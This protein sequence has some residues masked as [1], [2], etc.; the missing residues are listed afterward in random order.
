MLS[1]VNFSA[2]KCCETTSRPIWNKARYCDRTMPW[3][4]VAIGIILCVIGVLALKGIIPMGGA[5]NWLVVAGSI[6]IGVG[7]FFR[8][9]RPCS[10]CGNVV[11]SKVREFCDNRRR[12][13]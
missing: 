8:L 2:L 11:A 10:E 13:I 6:Q 1:V 5:G 12:A 3:I 7:L 4:D 9:L